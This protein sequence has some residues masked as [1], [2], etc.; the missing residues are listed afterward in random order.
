MKGKMRVVLSILLIV[1]MV[2]AIAPVVIGAPLQEYPVGM[3]AYWRL[4]E[5]SGAVATDSF[6]GNDGDVYGATWTTG[7][8]NGALSFDGNDYL[9]IPDSP[10]LNSP[11]ISVSLWVRLAADAPAGGTALAEKDGWVAGQ[12]GYAL[13]IG[14]WG[15]DNTLRFEVFGPWT[16]V[17]STFGLE[18]NRWYHVVA[19]YDQQ[20]MRIYIDGQLNNSIAETQAINVG[21]NGILGVGARFGDFGKTQEVNLLGMVDEMAIY[22]RALAVEEIQQHYQNG[23]AGLGYDAPSGT[24]LIAIPATP[25]VYPGDTVAVD[26]DTQGANDLY[27]AQATCTV[28][29]AILEPQSGVFG[30]A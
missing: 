29:A 22:N 16:L 14:D 18:L 23:L 30:S 21:N 19:T 25:Q 10:D 20:H 4:D 28:A 3:V 7:Q 17:D 15:T 6:D 5:D 13:L 2:M 27:A 24:S 8:V 1:T 9:I 26:L 12:T 11:N